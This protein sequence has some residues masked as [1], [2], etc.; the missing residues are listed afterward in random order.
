MIRIYL[1]YLT[2]IYLKGE[3]RGGGATV[4]AAL[5]FF[6]YIIILNTVVPISL[7]VRY[8]AYNLDMHQY[9]GLIELKCRLLL[10]V[11]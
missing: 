10:Y 6:S 9:V 11:R 3:S 5:V 7:Y 1:I 8:V 4:I 2:I